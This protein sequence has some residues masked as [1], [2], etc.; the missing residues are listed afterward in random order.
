MAPYL[1]GIE[2]WFILTLF[3]YKS[4]QQDSKTE[5]QMHLGIANT[6]NFA[7]KLKIIAAGQ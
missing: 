5:V 2:D 3:I 4:L 7:A 6:T 1:V